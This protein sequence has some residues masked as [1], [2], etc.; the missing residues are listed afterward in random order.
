MINKKYLV[1]TASALFANVVSF[2]VLLFIDVGIVNGLLYEFGLQFDSRWANLYWNYVWMGLTLIFSACLC[3]SFSLALLTRTSLVKPKAAVSVEESLLQLKLH[4]RKA[5]GRNSRLV[6]AVFLVSS[7]A[8][9]S[10]AYATNF[11]A[12]EVTSIFAFLLGIFLLLSGRRN[13]VDLRVAKALFSPLSTLCDLLQRLGIKSPGAYVPTMQKHD[14][15]V[16]IFL[17]KG[18]N[19]TSIYASE[20]T[21]PILGENGFLVPSVGNGLLNV[22]EEELGDVRKL[23]LDHLIG[24]LPRIY[25]EELRIVQKLEITQEKDI[26]HVKLADAAFNSLCQSTKNAEICRF[27]GCPLISSVAE[28][29]AKNTGRIIFY[30]SCINDP[31]AKT[32]ETIFRIGPPA[33][34]M[35]RSKQFQKTSQN[36]SATT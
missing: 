15:P 25:K 6:G 33:E 29:I 21:T 13:T 11:I 9:F 36:G 17:S 16:A 22:V 12:F 32:S 18:S 28:A 23:T 26:I 5:R 27:V 10:L 20:P 35:E 34:K 14:Q 8:F 2:V 1:L 19:D 31:D 4:L 7:G 30:K 3:M 24:W